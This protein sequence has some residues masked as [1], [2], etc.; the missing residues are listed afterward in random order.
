VLVQIPPTLDD[1]CVGPL[2]LICDKSQIDMCNKRGSELSKSKAGNPKDILD[3]SYYASILLYTSNAIYR[4]LNKVL[5]EENRKAIK[6]YMK[7]LRLFLQAMDTLPQR[8]VTLWRGIS[9]DLFD[10][11]PVGKT[12]TWWGISSCTLDEQVARNFASGCGGQSTMLTVHAKRACD[13]S[14]I[15][16]YASEKESLLAPGTQLMVRSAKRKGK[17]AEIVL[18]EIGRAI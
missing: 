1:A 5:R 17:V 13:I 11:Y 4:E 10:Q 14:E 18:E 15:T 12:I 2:G 6:K 9:V 16:F 7:Y 3:H 8:E